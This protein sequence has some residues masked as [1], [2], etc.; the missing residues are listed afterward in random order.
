MV[1]Q[2]AQEPSFVDDLLRRLK[3]LPSPYVVLFR[4]KQMLTGSQ[5]KLTEVQKK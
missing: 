4:A 5:V 1:P 2:A 3:P